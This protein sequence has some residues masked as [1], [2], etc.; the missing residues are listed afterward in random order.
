[1]NIPLRY[2]FAR[3]YSTKCT[4]PKCGK[5]KVFSPYVDTGTGELLPEHVGKCDRLDKC[6][7]HYPP[8]DYFRDNG[9]RPDHA[10]GT[11]RTPKPEP[12]PT[13][14]H[15]HKRAEVAVLRSHPERNTLTSY[16]RERIG[17]ELW[18]KVARD[19]ALGTWPSFPMAGAAVYWQV[20]IH[21]HV[22]GA[23]VMLYD[24]ATGHRDK[25]GGTTWVHSLTGGIP[26]GKR[27]EQCLFGEHLL[28]DWPMDAPVAVVE[29]EKTAMIAAAL[30]PKF[31]WVS[32]GSLSEFK[33]SKLQALTGRHVVAFPD[34]STG[35]T[36][37]TKWREK[38]TEMA[39]L[40][41]SIQVSDILEA[42]ATVETTVAGMDIADLLL[43]PTPTSA[44]TSTSPSAPA[45]ANP[46]RPPMPP[47]VL[48]E[49]E[50]LFQRMATR[51][52]V[53]HTLSQVLDL[54]FEQA[55]RIG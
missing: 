1:M 29:S 3:G 39:G 41:A 21:G 24:P 15:L 20:D 33:L 49:A 26:D 37:Y 43:R 18:D 40:F 44:T 25:Q 27:L 4:C 46:T 7:H 50:I 53:L 13:P 45:L 36:A 10:D 31:C 5:R 42:G 23:K 19:Y 22:K 47:M 16:W 52:P 35:S 51:N 54:D 9:I 17:A 6:A 34:L 38:A 14:P 8:R 30:L 11:K 55:Q 32:V 28:R 2:Q 12:P 48:S